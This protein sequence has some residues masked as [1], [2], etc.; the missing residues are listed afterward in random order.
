MTRQKYYEALLNEMEDI[1]SAF[2]NLAILLV[3]N[4][5]F[6][7]QV[8]EDIGTDIPF[9]HSIEEMLVHLK[10]WIEAFKTKMP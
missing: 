5:N 8:N 2:T 1:R 3:D 4:E 6:D 7:D 10:T 9:T